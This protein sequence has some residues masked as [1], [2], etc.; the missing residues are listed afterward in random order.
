MR[1]PRKV[2]LIILGCALV[3][4]LF[5]D[6]G[7]YALRPQSI[8]TT[9]DPLDYRLAALS[10]LH[11]GEFSFAPPSFHAPQLL[12]TP[13]YPFILAGT[14]LLDGQSGLAMI[15]LQSFLL[16]AMGWL[17]FKLLIA[18][19]VPEKISL[20]LVALYLLEPF[21]W[22]YTLQTMTETLA[23]FFVLA[24]I[25]A[26][27]VGKG[28]SNWSR[29]ALYG[30]GLG[31]LMLEK[32]S[33]E[34]WIPFLLVLVLFAA[35]NWRTRFMR[36]GIALVMFFFTLSPWIIRNYE[37]TG[38]PVVSSSS[39]YA[40]IEFAGTPGT[41]T[42]PSDFRDVVMMASYNGHSNEVWYAY[43]TASYGELVAADRAILAQLNY[44]WFVERQLACAPSIWFGFIN[45]KD[46]ESYGHEYSLIADFV[47]GTN[48]LRDAF[49]NKID[50]IIWSLVLVLSA[51]GTFLLLRDSSTRWRFLSLL[52]MLFAALLVND[53][54]AWVRVL[55]P[56]Y[57][58][59]FVAT[60]AGVAYV[61]SKIRTLI[62]SHN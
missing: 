49:I 10:I 46:Q 27:L 26:A 2:L 22:L 23:S 4:H 39:E 19:R 62:K 37:L 57:P 51:L 47:A 53:C 29:A 32:P 28:I 16:V 45:Q 8:S 18:F 33:A 40:L 38:Y 17:L 7:V 20:V 61:I 35:G 25:A 50:T 5:S 21:Q 15:I 60:G 14:Y 41:A 6:I 44:P 55:L 42:W 59:I 30:I 13:I 58:V 1:V 3:L 48:A 12:R 24:L 31:V 43:T 36:V 9:P 54:A 52:G 11:Y 56:V 34:M